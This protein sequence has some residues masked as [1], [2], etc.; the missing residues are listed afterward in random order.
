MT[1]STFRSTV[2][3][4]LSIAIGALL[5]GAS[6]F[7]A[8][9]VQAQSVAKPPISRV[10]PITLSFVNAEIEA[11]ARTMA[12]IMGVNLVVDPRVKGTMTL[13]TEKPVSRA[14]AINQFTAALRLQ[15]FTMVESGNLYRVVPEA[16]AKLQ[17]GTVAVGEAAPAAAVGNRSSPRF[18][19]STMSQPTTWYPCCGP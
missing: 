19:V 18:F 9:E 3:A 10:A 14:V 4:I 7:F 17:S 6:G 16:D 8:P 12:T 1:S 13:F 5:A 15:G 2:A 11:V